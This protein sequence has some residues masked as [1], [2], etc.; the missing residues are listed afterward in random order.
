MGK[1]KTRPKGAM[2]AAN[3]GLNFAVAVALLS[4]LG[5]KLDERRGGGTTWTLCG[6][7]LGLIYGFYE[8]WKMVRISAEQDKDD[9]QE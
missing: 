2:G 4:Y 9:Q 6:I 1:R 5:H 3:L 7:F 8:V